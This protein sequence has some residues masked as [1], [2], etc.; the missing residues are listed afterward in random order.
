MIGRNCFDTHQVRTSP[1]TPETD[2]HKQSQRHG[3][4]SGLT[5]SKKICISQPVQENGV[6]SCLGTITTTLAF[7]SFPRAVLDPHTYRPL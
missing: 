2:K 4:S 3:R 5:N 7:L 1:N 6:M